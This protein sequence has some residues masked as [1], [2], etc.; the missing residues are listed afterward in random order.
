VHICHVNN[1]SAPIS[2]RPASV[3]D[4]AVPGHWEGDLIGG[5]KNSYIATLGERHSRYVTLATNVDV[6]F[7]DPGSPWQ[8]GS[9]EK[10]NRLLRQYLPGGT[11]LSLH[12]QANLNAV[13][14]QSDSMVH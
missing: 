1:E 6:Y 5:S 7:Y 13:V 4:R 11:D 10:T 8:R 9:N 14:R 12:S 2:E 3:K